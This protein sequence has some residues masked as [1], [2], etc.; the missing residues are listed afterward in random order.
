MRTAT[1]A[2]ACA[3]ALVACRE[4]APRPAP[5]IPLDLM[6]RKAAEPKAEA[7]S[8]DPAPAPTGY[9][10]DAT[11]RDLLA[12][13][14]Y[15]ARSE[16]PSAELLRKRYEGRA[17][18]S[19]VNGKETTYELGGDVRS[20]TIRENPSGVGAS[21]RLIIQDD[22]F[23]ER[24]ALTDIESIVETRRARYMPG[25]RSEGV[26]VQPGRSTPEMGLVGCVELGDRVMQ[27]SAEITSVSGVKE[28][29]VRFE[30]QRRC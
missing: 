19:T 14:L 2:A 3:A 15:Q 20:M 4:P 16:L 5:L 13:L 22:Q 21:V 7:R 9:T 11:V 8:A 27:V 1:V 30:R 17:T 23:V 18:A 24:R 28:V 25:Q 12:D 26:I 6:D 29:Y 10:G